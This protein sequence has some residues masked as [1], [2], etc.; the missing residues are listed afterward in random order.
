MLHKYEMHTT[1]MR[2]HKFPPNAWFA[3]ISARTPAHLING[4]RVGAYTPCCSATSQQRNRYGGTFCVNPSLEMITIDRTRATPNLE[5]RAK[6]FL[7]R[8]AMSN[9]VIRLLFLAPYWANTHICAHGFVGNASGIVCRQTRWVL[10]YA[11]WAG[12]R[13]GRK[14]LWMNSLG[15]VPACALLLNN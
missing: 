6:G 14:C 3:A 1:K 7:W 15:A 11:R 5:N 13:T 2:A 12:V 9:H 4:E 8:F 10:A